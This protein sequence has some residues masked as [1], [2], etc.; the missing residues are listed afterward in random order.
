MKRRLIALIAMLVIGLQSSLVAFAASPLMSTDCQTAAA[1]QSDASENSCCPKGQQ[2][3]SCCLVACLTAAA[4]AV[5]PASS[6][7]YGRTASALPSSSM[8]FSSRGDMPLI[9]P[10]I[11]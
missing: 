6:L 3:M 4:V 9:R 5:S 8:A 7:W 1:A 11:L 10:P 2:T